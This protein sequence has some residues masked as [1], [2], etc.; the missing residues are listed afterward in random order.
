M[1][2]FKTSLSMGESKTIVGHTDGGSHFEGSGRLW[3][4][5][6]RWRISYETPE[7]APYEPTPI[8]AIVREY[9]S[10][11]VPVVHD[12]MFEIVMFD[13][14]QDWKPELLWRDPM[15]FVDGWI[16]FNHMPKIVQT[17]RIGFDAFSHA[18]DWDGPR[19][20][21]FHAIMAATK[22][23]N[24]HEPD[25][26]EMMYYIAQQYARHF[27]CYQKRSTKFSSYAAKD[28]A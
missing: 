27:Q 13:F 6:A 4:E 10:S 15:A 3:G 20:E 8:R 22:R 21:V 25:V 26:E 12:R 5:E 24:L 9:Y 18:P 7:W 11:S 16:D 23:V 17:Q 1:K 19:P 2:L 28:K 14:K